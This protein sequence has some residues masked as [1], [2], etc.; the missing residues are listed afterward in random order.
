MRGG[1]KMN[2]I[3]FILALVVLIYASFFQAERLAE[4][5]ARED[6]QKSIM[7]DLPDEPAAE[8]W[9]DGPGLTPSKHR[10][11]EARCFNLLFLEK[12]YILV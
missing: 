7:E 8:E 2:K 3:L 1:G 5:N 12:K 11:L 10:V 9:R 4:Q 6:V